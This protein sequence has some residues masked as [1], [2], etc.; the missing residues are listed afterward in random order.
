MILYTFDRI[1][2]ATTRLKHLTIL[3]PDQKILGYPHVETL[4]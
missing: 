1:I 2:A 3:T 4:S